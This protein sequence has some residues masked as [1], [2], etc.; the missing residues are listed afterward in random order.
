MSKCS[1]LTCETCKH[2]QGRSEYMGAC[3]WVI[4]EI[5]PWFLKVKNIFG[6]GAN[7]PFDSHDLKYYIKN[8]TL[9]SKLTI[10]TWP[11]AGVGIHCWKEDDITFG[12][13]KGE[14]TNERT[15]PTWQFEFRTARDKEGC[16][17]Y[18]ALDA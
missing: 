17:Y 1:Q 14:I 11:A 12:F 10:A 13:N 8:K 2:W 3:H 5:H 15:G 16:K 9:Y 6:W 4:A 18:E 7:L